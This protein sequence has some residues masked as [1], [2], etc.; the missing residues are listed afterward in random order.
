M[1]K[2]DSPTRVQAAQ[3]LLI[4]DD[5]RTLRFSIGEWARDAG[6]T[7]REAANSREAL[8]AVREQGVDAVLLDLKLGDEDGLKVLKALREA[9][10]LLPVVMLTGHGTV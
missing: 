1:A 4:V 10:P 6:F 2:G 9:E 7:P 5:E 8:A 3:T